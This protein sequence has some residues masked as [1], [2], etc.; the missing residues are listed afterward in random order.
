LGSD[1]AV[2]RWSAEC[3]LVLSEGS[4]TQALGLLSER[5]QAMNSLC[6]NYYE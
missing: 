3:D 2:K 1:S 4:D 5:I 6:D